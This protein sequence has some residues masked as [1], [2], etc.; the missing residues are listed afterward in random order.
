MMDDMELFL[1]RSR[2]DL[3]R[4]RGGIGDMVR[5]VMTTKTMKLWEMDT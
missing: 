3:N 4:E 1:R 5:S 2:R